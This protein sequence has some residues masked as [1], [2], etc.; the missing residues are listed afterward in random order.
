MVALERA[1]RV[2]LLLLRVR[3]VVVPIRAVGWLKAP[4]ILLWH[5]AKN[6]VVV[7]ILGHCLLVL[8][9]TSLG[10]CLA[11][12]IVVNN[13]FELFHRM[14]LNLRHSCTRPS[15][16]LNLT[17]SIQ[18]L[19]LDIDL[20]NLAVLLKKGHGSIRVDQVL[21]LLRNEIFIINDLGYR[22]CSY[23]IPK[24]HKL[25]LLQVQGDWNVTIA[26]DCLCRNLLS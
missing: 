14:V 17:K 2:A 5:I 6:V 18:L 9:S 4:R 16:V 3:H 21:Q 25:F 11:Q 19:R 15:E 1:F 10:I 13:V 24:L 22:V 26:Y 7:K 20:F 12:I 23:L 8:L